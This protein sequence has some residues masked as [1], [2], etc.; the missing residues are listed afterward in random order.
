[1]SKKKKVSL[2][3]LALGCTILTGVACSAPPPT[4]TREPTVLRLVAADSCAPLADSLAVAYEKNHPWVTVQ[5]EVLNS[6]LAER[7]LRD[8]EAEIALLSW[9]AEGSYGRDRP[10]W[11]Q[12][13]VRDG[14]AIIV[15]PSLPLTE[16]SLA[17]LRDIFRGQVQE[18]DGTALTVVSREEGSGTRAVFD[19]IVLGV[20]KVT[21]TAVMFASSEAVIEYVAQTPGAI[22]YVSTLRL[23]DPT[24]AWVRVLSVEG[25]LPSQSAFYDG[26]YPLARPIYLVTYGE[27]VGET[28]EFA[29]WVV[30]PEGQMVYRQ[31]R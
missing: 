23:E 18:W 17:L 20:H 3:C 13:I 30:G 8:G 19:K 22:G 14:I 26:S 31:L 2:L 15:H 12:P 21:H 27:P 6:A 9:V 5:R 28:R 29:Q 1:M 16:V 25:V 24:R 10:L 7:A 4:A 11:A